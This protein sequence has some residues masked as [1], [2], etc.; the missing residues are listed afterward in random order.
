M[1]NCRK[2]TGWTAG[3]PQERA[4]DLIA[5]FA[6]P[7]ISVVIA[8]VGGNHS[9]Q[10]LDY[11][12]Y[13]V[14]ANNPKIF[15]G[16]SD[17]TTLHWA[18]MR[19][20]GLRTFYGPALISQLGEHPKPFEYTIDWMLKAWSGESLDFSPAERWTEEFLDWNKKLDL[21][22][23]RQLKSSTGWVCV[24][25]GRAEGFLLG[26][27]LETISWHLVGT[28]EWIDPQGALFFL[29]T[30]EEAP[31]PAQVDAYLTTLERIGVFDAA[32]GLVV[33]RA[34]G[35]DESMNEALFEVL[36]A[37]TARSQIPVLANFDIGHT[38][39]MVTLPMG[40]RARLDASDRLLE[41]TD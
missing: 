22:R 18:L 14:I 2:H 32:S 35:Y 41:T 20:A 30:S 13:E 36:E 29:E 10:V 39:P 24:R 34:Y 25:E 15:Q 21:E 26:G 5:A 16:Y 27:C 9:A 4:E 31:S 12:D 1:P 3:S 7:E 33:G 8:S 37:R 40:R 19:H 11:L 28:D 38:D 17:I 6:D 23:P